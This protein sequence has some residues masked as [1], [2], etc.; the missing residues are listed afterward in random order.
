MKA[1]GDIQGGITFQIKNDANKK[2]QQMKR[3][4]SNL[5]FDDDVFNSIERDIERKIIRLSLELEEDAKNIVKGKVPYDNSITREYDRSFSQHKKHLK[6]N[7]VKKMKDKGKYT[8][9]I[10]VGWEREYKKIAHYINYGVSEHKIKPKGDN[11]LKY[12]LP[13]SPNMSRGEDGFRY[14]KGGVFHPGFDGIHFLDSSL[15]EVKIIAD[16]KINSVFS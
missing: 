8:V 3:K 11:A 13:T 15:E 10:Y 5:G 4:A 9:E 7:I 6:D 14:V 16:R 12:P 1:E 2:V